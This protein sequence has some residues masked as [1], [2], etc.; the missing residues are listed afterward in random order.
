MQYKTI[1][2]AQN[3]SLS[4]LVSNLGGA[5]GLCAGFSLISAFEI[6]HLLFNI[7]HKIVN[8]PNKRIIPTL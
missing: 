2:E 3:I 8:N 7:L 5:L 6:V 4:D 1:E